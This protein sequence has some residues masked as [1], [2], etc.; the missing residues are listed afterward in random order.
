MSASEGGGKC[1]VRL[2][3]AA[4][5]LNAAHSPWVTTIPKVH[6]AWRHR[7]TWEPLQDLELTSQKT[8]VNVPPRSIANFNLRSPAML[9]TFGCAPARHTQDWRNTLAL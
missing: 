9:G 2:P 7:R 5:L 6:S 8:S 1:P 4:P 3:G